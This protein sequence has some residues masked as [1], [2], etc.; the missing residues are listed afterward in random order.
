[1]SVRA[2]TKPPTKDRQRVDIIRYVTGDVVPNQPFKKGAAVVLRVFLPGGHYQDVQVWGY[3]NT[4][5]RALQNAYARAT[6][7]FGGRI[8]FQDRTQV[9][10][11]VDGPPRGL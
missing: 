10:I 4:E 1:M 9:E 3:S 5:T 8:D 2:I 7:E 6:R 11:I